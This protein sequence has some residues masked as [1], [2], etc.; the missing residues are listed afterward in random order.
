MMRLKPPSTPNKLN[1]AFI[2]KLNPT[3]RQ[4]SAYLNHQSPCHARKRQTLE[5][6]I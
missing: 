2:D 5:D 1:T 3:I 6:Q 4:G